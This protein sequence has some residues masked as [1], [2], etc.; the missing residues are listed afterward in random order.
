MEKRE[1]KT[2][3][4]NEVSC[5]LDPE[6]LKTILRSKSD[7]YTVLTQHRKHSFIAL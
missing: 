6:D 2:N 1:I 3:L 4:E 7:L 5:E